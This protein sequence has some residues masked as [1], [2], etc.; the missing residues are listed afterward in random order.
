MKIWLGSS[1]ALPGETASRPW[2][3]P[4]GCPHMLGVAL[5]QD[6]LCVAG[7]TA[8]HETC[9]IVSG[10]VLGLE[11]IEPVIRQWHRPQ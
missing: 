2:A 7:Y 6:L 4:S 5:G 10:R 3:D 9:P 11:R 8:A 1:L